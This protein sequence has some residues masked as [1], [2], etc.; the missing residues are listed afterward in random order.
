MS[1]INNIDHGLHGGANSDKCEAAAKAY[2]EHKK[3]MAKMASGDVSQENLDTP[4]ETQE[5]AIEPVQE[6][7]PAAWERAAQKVREQPSD[8]PVYSQQKPEDDDQVIK[9]PNKHMMFE[10]AYPN[11][12][13]GLAVTMKARD[14]NLDE[15]SLS[16]LMDDSVTLKMPKWQ[17]LYVKLYDI[18]AGEIIKKVVWGGGTHTFGKVK[19]LSFIIVTD[20]G[21]ES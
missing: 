6:N 1:D 19:H 9:I 20:N 12:E 2:L 21:K 14:I 18:I 7:K 16:I 15:D 3:L 11:F 5:Q 4:S 17:P 10:I 8:T 13:T